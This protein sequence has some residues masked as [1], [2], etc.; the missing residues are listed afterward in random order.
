MDTD[1]TQGSICQNKNGEIER[2][3]RSHNKFK[4][5]NIFDWHSVKNQKHQD[6]QFP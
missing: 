6:N 3:D 4:K 2:N 5:E 1:K